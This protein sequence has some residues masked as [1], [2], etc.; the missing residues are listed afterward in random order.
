V[1]DLGRRPSDARIRNGDGEEQRYSNRNPKACE[2]LLDWMEP[3]ACDVE[4]KQRAWPKSEQRHLPEAS[5]DPA[6][7]SSPS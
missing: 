7:I 3:K 5:T 4:A 1:N 2:Q 6:G